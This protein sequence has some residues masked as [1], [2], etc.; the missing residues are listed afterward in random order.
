[1]RMEERTDETEV[2]K[3]VVDEDDV[4]E[5]SDDD[6]EKETSEENVIVQS[7]DRLKDVKREESEVNDTNEQKD[8][9]DMIEPEK[10]TRSGRALRRPKEYEDYEPFW[11]KGSVI[12]MYIFGG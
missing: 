12:L 3:T 10:I 2:L 4:I 5:I 7:D 9:N 6:N 11:K 1:M 8:T